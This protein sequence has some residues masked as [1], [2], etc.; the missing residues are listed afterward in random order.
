MSF[1]S[2]SKFLALKHTGAY[3]P[4]STLLP[5]PSPNPHH[6]TIALQHS[7]NKFFWFGLRERQAQFPYLVKLGYVSEG[8]DLYYFSFI[9]KYPM[10]ARSLHSMN[11]PGN[12]WFKV[13][14]DCAQ[15][16]LSIWLAINCCSIS[17][18]MEGNAIWNTGL[19]EN[20]RA[21]SID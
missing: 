17:M 12:K 21:V 8:R 19:G 2:G 14:L 11:H 15:E 20:K 13:L 7:I 5:N 1:L 6:P 3:L 4:K 16:G 10:T 9:Q 18:L